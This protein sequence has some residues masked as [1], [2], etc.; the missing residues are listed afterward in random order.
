MT[1]R[2]VPPAFDLYDIDATREHSLSELSQALQ[3]Q[4]Q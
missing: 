3:E 2:Y 4:P 1:Y